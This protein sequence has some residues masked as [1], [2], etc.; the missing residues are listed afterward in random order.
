MPSSL[1]EFAKANPGTRGRT[2]WLC[3]IPERA[4]VEKGHLDGVLV[5]VIIR[6]LKGRG[7]TDA[8]ATRNR[9]HY[10]FGNDHHITG[11]SKK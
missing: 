10:H 11:Q 2:C 8:D 4:E 6:W 9:I 5:P 3:L 7:Y 1:L